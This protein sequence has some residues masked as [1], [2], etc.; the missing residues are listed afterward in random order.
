[1]SRTFVSFSIEGWIML[2]YRMIANDLLPHRNKY[3]SILYP[4]FI[5]YFIEHYEK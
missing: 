2:S 5:L 4:S 3:A 1:M